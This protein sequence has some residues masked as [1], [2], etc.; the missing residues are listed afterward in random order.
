MP[1]PQ[2][3]FLSKVK[4]RAWLGSRCVLC[5]LLAS[6]GCVPWKVDTAWW[7]G[8]Q[9]YYCSHFY[10]RKANEAFVKA[11]EQG[12]EERLFTPSNTLNN[13]G[14]QGI[15]TCCF[16]SW[17]RAKMKC[18]ECLAL[19]RD[20]FGLEICGPGW[21]NLKVRWGDAIPSLP[22]WV[23]PSLFWSLSTCTNPQSLS[24]SNKY[25]YYR[26]QKNTSSGRIMGLAL[27]DS[28]WRFKLAPVDINRRG[29]VILFILSLNCRC[30]LR[31]LDENF[32]KSL[33][34]DIWSW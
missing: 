18:W 17:P 8:E 15:G 29:V 28:A 22:E 6:A 32:C 21:G 4:L 23:H 9:L 30:F 14:A 5:D 19:E 3:L 25:I 27:A 16:Q 1:E 26:Q 34:G 24:L 31:C 13:K 12:W 11:W 20:C 10:F 7:L 2:I 33:E